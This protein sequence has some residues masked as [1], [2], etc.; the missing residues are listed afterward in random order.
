MIVSFLIYL[1]QNNESAKKAGHILLKLALVAQ[2]A[3]IAF[4]VSGV[5][6]ATDVPA[7]LKAQLAANPTQYAVAG[8][9]IAERENLS[10]RNLPR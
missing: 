5:K 3:A 1:Y 9:A 10:A 7:E 2:L 6:S 4:Y 8:R